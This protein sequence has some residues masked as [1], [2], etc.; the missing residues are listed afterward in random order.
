[1]IES[2]VASRIACF[3]ALGWSVAGLAA[4]SPPQRSRT[5]NDVILDWLVCE[6][7][8]AGQRDS[9]IA[10]GGDA[11]P[12]LA[13][14]IDTVPAVVTAPLRTRLGN[15]WNSGLGIDS[16]TYVQSFVENAESLAR[17]RAA[18]S[19]G[20]LHAISELNAALTLARSRSYRD[21]V[22]RA[23]LGAIASASSPVSSTMTAIRLEPD[24]VDLPLGRTGHLA[25]FMTDSAG[26][27]VQ[28][29]VSWSSSD[30]AIVSVLAD[31]ELT[32]S[33]VGI[34][35]VTAT[36]GQYSA[37]SVVTV[38]PVPS[39]APVVTIRSGDHQSADR[40]GALPDTLRVIVQTTSGTAVSEIAVSWTVLVGGGTVTGAPT[41]SATGVATARWILGPAAGPQRLEARVAGAPAVV[42]RATAR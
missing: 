25:V 6:E 41:T 33:G 22:V 20:D 14:V 21:D 23:I 5:S 17:I 35:T 27:L 42:F 7:C 1:V 30:P 34:A 12:T 9:V 15:R 32:G 19:L 40:G 29:S 26:N 36:S 10:L 18:Q 3:I 8:T 13:S 11:V 38:V 37:T 4:C 16:A 28:D 24:S 31:G 2:S 39:P